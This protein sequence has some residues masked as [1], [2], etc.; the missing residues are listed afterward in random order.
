MTTSTGTV[1]A[2]AVAAASTVGCASYPGT[3]RPASLED[4]RGEEGWVLLDSVPFVRQVSEKG[5][6]AACLAMVLGHWGCETPVESLERECAV[7]D[8]DGIRAADLRDAARRRGMS[9][10]LF[11]GDVAT[12]EHELSRG[13]PVVVGVVKPNGDAFT[14]HF[15][16]V[17]GL[18]R[19]RERIA[20]LDPA[21]GLLCDSLDGFHDEW[22][23]TKSVTLVV[24]AP[25]A[26]P[27]TMIAAG[28]ERGGK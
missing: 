13:R 8:R 22:R 28:T 21:L 15:E 19:G 11:R 17:V 16:V 14:T 27:A 18:H 2:L 23:P 9:A 1:L 10:F 4:L 20:V 12:L 24:F 25:G 5:C 26:A 6:G 3:A 7:S